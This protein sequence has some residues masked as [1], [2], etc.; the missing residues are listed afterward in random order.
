[1]IWPE[2]MIAKIVFEAV[3][4]LKKEFFSTCIVLKCIFE[5]FD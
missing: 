1:M 2:G 5:E 3:N 4:F